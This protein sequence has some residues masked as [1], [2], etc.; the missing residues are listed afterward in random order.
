MIFLSQLPNGKVV[1]AQDAPGQQAPLSCEHLGSRRKCCP[2]LWI[3]RL[4]RRS[5]I[6]APDFDRV[7]GKG[8]Q[9]CRDCPDRQ[10]AASE[11]AQTD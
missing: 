11:A 4:S 10:S 6:P 2:D 1:T 8:V 7:V 5:C 9:L 3:C